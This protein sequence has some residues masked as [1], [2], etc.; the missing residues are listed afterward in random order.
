MA[1]LPAAVASRV[2][3]T[4]SAAP[5]GRARALRAS[6]S[7]AEIFVVTVALASAALLVFY[8]TS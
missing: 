7:G 6:F 5:G 1:A 3:R 8:L 2:A 4:G